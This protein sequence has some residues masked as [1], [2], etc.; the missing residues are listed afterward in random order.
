MTP[1]LGIASVRDFIRA[2]KE[3]PGKFKYAWSGIGAS[4]HLTMELFKSMA[5]ID[6]VHVPYKNAGQGYA[7]PDLQQ[8]FV[9]NGVAAA[10]VT[11]EEFV[12]FVNVEIA[13]WQKVVT[14]SGAKVE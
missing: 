9:D 10:P 14:I 12:K 5:G 3:S 7:V 1:S 2:A 6:V 11:P 4:P 13:K 8:R